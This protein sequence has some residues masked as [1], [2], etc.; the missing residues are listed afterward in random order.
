MPL[1]IK[2]SNITMKIKEDLENEEMRY[3]NDYNFKY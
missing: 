3:V 2:P 1:P